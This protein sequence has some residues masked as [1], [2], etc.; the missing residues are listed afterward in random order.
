MSDRIVNL[1][2]LELQPSDM[3]RE[4]TNVFDERCVGE[5][6]GSKAT[7]LSVYEVGPGKRVWP[8]HF[9][10]GS[11]EWLIVLSGELVLRTPE[12]EQ[13]VRA[14][15][16]ACFPNGPTGAHAVWNDGAEVARFVMFSSHPQ[17]AGGVVYPDSG[18]FAFGGPGF[19][20][21]GRLGEPV[22]YWEGEP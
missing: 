6:F 2:D 7:G 3:N 15:D 21:R 11:E 10:L 12:G 8:Y 22:E 20:H 4:P 14:G 16:V 5:E 13:T 1:R 17:L 19:D 9:E 18:N